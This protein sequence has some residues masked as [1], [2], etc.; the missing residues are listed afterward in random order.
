MSCRK[1]GGIWFVRV[2]RIGFTFYI[3]RRKPK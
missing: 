3:A 1:V 2:W